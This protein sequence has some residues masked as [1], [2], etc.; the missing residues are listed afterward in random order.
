M[1]AALP[2]LW[3]H[4]PSSLDIDPLNLLLDRLHDHVDDVQVIVTT[5]G[6]A[7]V[8]YGQLGELCALPGPGR[9]DISDFLRKH[10]P[11]S[12]LWV[13]CDAHQTL[14]RSLTSA[15]IGL[16][17]VD[18]G[19]LAHILTG[20]SIMARL[21]SPFRLVTSATYS[22]KK[23]GRT[24][25]QHGLRSRQMH[26]VGLLESTPAPLDGDENE[27]HRLAQH[28][29][30][31]PVW[32]A[33]GINPEELDPILN[34]HL[35]ALRHS[36]RLLLVV[37][38]HVPWRASEF[39][40]VLTEQSV[41][42]G[43]SSLEDAPSPDSEIYLV[44]QDDQLGLWYRLAPLSFIGQTLSGRADDG[45]DPIHATTLGSVVIH[46]P[47]I[48]QHRQAFERLQR[49]GA[50]REVKNEQELAA[51]VAQLLAPDRAA[52]LAHAAWNTTTSGSEVVDHLVRL[53]LAD[54]ERASA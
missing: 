16:H 50:V 7:P 34:A 29:S 22:D 12:A 44:D 42:F 27:R 19:Q 35:Q 43:I 23:T 39:A 37:I 14:F 41:A 13:D 26:P 51:T 47:R 2:T 3:L 4:L 20:S 38:P 45:P 52:A 18:A 48:G 32:L 40:R 31:R 33:A 54:F 46:G 10:T 53:I 11:Q 9:R 1:P 8:Q 17:L 30:G 5:D 28:L 6:A 25:S 21:R 49:A 15:E 24:L 36:H